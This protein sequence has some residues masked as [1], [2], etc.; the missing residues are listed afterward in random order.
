MLYAEKTEN[1]QTIITDVV[2]TDPRNGIGRNI[3]RELLNSAHDRTVRYASHQEN[4]VAIFYI[5]I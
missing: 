2:A 4:D 5:P 1:W 3:V